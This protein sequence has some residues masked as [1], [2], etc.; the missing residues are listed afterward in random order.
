MQKNFGFKFTNGVP[1][2]KSMYPGLNESSYIFKKGSVQKE[3]AIP[4]SCDILVEQDTP[5]KLRDGI[6]IRVDIYRPVNAV[7]CPVIL[8]YAP[9]GKR[10]SFFNMDTFGHPT[11]MD[12][13]R[14]WEDGLNSFE[15]PNPSYWVAHGYAVISPDPRGVGSSEGYIYT[16]STQQT[17][18]E[19]DLIE[20][21]AAQSWCNGK[22][23]TTGTSYLAM[24]QYAIAA[25]QPPHLAA[26]A[27]WEGS[28]SLFKD[29][30]AK[31]GIK[32]LNFFSAMTNAIYT[33]T[34]I[35]DVGSM[36]QEHPYYDEYWKDKEADL[37]SIQIPSYIVA[38]WTN[39]I[40]TAGSIKAFEHI[41]SKEKWL[42]VNNT[43]EWHD[44]YSPENVED[45][46]KFFDYYLIGIK[47]DWLSTPKVRLSV[48]NPGHE[49]IVNRAEESFPLRNQGQKTLY[50][51]DDNGQLTLKD[52]PQKNESAICYDTNTLDGVRFTIKIPEVTEFIGNYSLKLYVESEGNNDMDIYAYIRKRDING[53]IVETKTVTDRTFVGPNGQLRVSCRE[54]DSK[55]STPLEPVLKMTG[56]KKL[57]EHEIAEIE[58]PFWPYG[59]KW[60]ADEILELQICPIEKIS[61]PELPQLPP[62]KTLN[63][64]RHIIHIGGQYDSQ[65]RLPIIIK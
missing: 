16:W 15:A 22:V 2:E 29:S 11:R 43:H 25:A 34:G 47:N 13:Q 30:I 28:T 46:R 40:H 59:M 8:W 33:N 10:G 50:L 37:S 52:T 64:G 27:P 57:K 19:F 7:N 45:L 54:L 60:E 38:S 12:V 23:G 24:T 49:D 18:D 55:L 65:L 1:L 39:V 4:L 35:E 3:G 56:E 6:T 62:V 42:R 48:L 14:N 5:V 26:I 20:W 31:G 32:D 41:S 58:I 21:A 44:Y 51:S 53:N 9:Y 17:E 36:I 61:R 63:K